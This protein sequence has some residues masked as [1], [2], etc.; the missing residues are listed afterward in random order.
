MILVDKF[1]KKITGYT[2]IEILE[3]EKEKQS[4]ENEIMRIPLCYK[5]KLGIMDKK[6]FCIEN[7]IFEE[8]DINNSSNKIPLINSAS[9]C[10]AVIG[11][12]GSGKSLLTSKILSK[13]KKILYFGYMDRDYYNE[14]SQRNFSIDFDEKNNIV[15]KKDD[16]TYLPNQINFYTEKYMVDIISI[17]GIELPYWTA[18]DKDKN[19]VDSLYSIIKSFI[20][21]ALKYNY[22]IVFDERYFYLASKLDAN[23][24]SEFIAFAYDSLKFKP[25]T[26]GVKIVISAHNHLFK[27]ILFKSIKCSHYIDELILVDYFN[28]N[29]IESL[30][31]LNHAYSFFM[32]NYFNNKINL[33]HTKVGD[34]IH[35]EKI[36]D[37]LDEC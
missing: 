3:L 5:Y 24:L 19:T 28:S 37:D 33:T 35:F 18:K 30:K 34:Y 36:Q 9:N 32:G 14:Q 16:A 1:I 12:S 22:S 20:A 4:L 26:D 7:T 29:K 23:K 21:N 17:S 8:K 31:N 13:S 10:I 2:P 15:F 25:K 6:G 11:D 27:D